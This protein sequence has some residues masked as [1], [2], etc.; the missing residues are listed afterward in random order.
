MIKAEQ[1]YTAQI[2][3]S[4]KTIAAASTRV[5]C[6]APPLR[7]PLGGRGFAEATEASLCDLGGLRPGCVFCGAFVAAATR[8]GTSAPVIDT[9]A[10]G[11]CDTAS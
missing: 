7:K 11:E 10:G 9:V 3:G 2:L 1:L 8:S 4:R 5:L 6:L